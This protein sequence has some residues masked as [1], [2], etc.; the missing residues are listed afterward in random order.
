LV[1]GCNAG[2]GVGKE[3]HR[4]GFGEGNIGLNSYLL[5]ERIGLAEHDASRIDH[6]KMAAVPSSVGIEAISGYA[7]FVFDDG[8][9]FPY[10]SIEERAFADV[11]PTHDHHDRQ[12]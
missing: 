12:M 3:K 5:R 4:V 1:V 9:K 2:G 11:R 7:G 8:K 6:L 10:E